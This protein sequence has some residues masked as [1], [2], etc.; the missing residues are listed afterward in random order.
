MAAL[1]VVMGVAVP[2]LVLAGIGLLASGRWVFGTLSLA[3]AVVLFYLFEWMRA[4]RARLK[5][6]NQ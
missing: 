1:L 3:G 2:V 6:R 5:S 4:L